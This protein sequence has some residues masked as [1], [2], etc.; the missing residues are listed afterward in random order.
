MQLSCCSGRIV[1]KRQA[2][3]LETGC[4]SRS[5]PRTR[6]VESPW[7]LRNE[8]SESRVQCVALYPRQ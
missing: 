8:L 6:L 4:F 5:S 3:F 2:I 7:G 1:V